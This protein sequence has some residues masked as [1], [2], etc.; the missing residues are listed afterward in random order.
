M[1]FI[2]RFFF[3][4]SFLRWNTIRLLKFLFKIVNVKIVFK[5]SSGMSSFKRHVEVHKRKKEVPQEY[6]DPR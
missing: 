1:L 2:N 4:F 3:L 6:A 5:K